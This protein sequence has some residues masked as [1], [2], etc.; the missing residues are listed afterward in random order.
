MKDKE[1]IEIE[2][3]HKSWLMHLNA[4]DQSKNGR[5][6]K[7]QIFLSFDTFFYFYHERKTF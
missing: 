4:A 7:K 1:W 2:K 6:K 5:I 3:N